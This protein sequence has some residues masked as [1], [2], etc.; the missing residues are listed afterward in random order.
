MVTQL[1]AAHYMIFSISAV[2]LFILMSYYASTNT[3]TSQLHSHL[4]KGLH[5]HPQNSSLNG[6]NLGKLKIL[7][8][9][10]KLTNFCLFLELNSSQ[11]HTD[12]NNLSSILLKGL[13][14]PSGT[15]N[16]T[17]L[18]YLVN[19]SQAELGIVN[20]EPLKGKIALKIP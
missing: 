19:Q 12:V 8:I 20:S 4:A 10:Q 6:A 5:H 3:V 17:Y 7:K 1:R 13:V 18:Q 9:H 2:S 11:S 16:G 14:S 15:V